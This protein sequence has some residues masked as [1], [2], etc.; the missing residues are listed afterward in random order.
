MMWKSS[1]LIRIIPRLRSRSAW[2]GKFRAS[3]DGAAVDNNDY[4]LYNTALGALL[5]DNDGSG[6]GVAVQFATLTS[7]PVLIAADFMIVA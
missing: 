4:I 1:D 7:K 2:R 6:A 5:Y 3:G